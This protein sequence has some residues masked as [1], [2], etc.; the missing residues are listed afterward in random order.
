MASKVKSKYK[1]MLL[2]IPDGIV[3]NDK[4]REIAETMKTNFKM[5]EIDKT[6]YNGQFREFYNAHILPYDTIKSSFCQKEGH[7]VVNI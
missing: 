1:N 5:N 3:P 4:T 6:E 7:P 2:W